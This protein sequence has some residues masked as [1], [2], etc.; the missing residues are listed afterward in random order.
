MEK[1]KDKF[2]NFSLWKNYLY[3]ENADKTIVLNKHF[4]FIQI[5]KTSSTN[6]LKESTK[7]RL[8]TKMNCYRH[9]GLA[10]K[11]SIV[12]NF[13]NYV[14]KNLDNIHTKQCIFLKSNRNIKVKTFKIE[15][16]DFNDYLIK[17][18]NI[19]L[20]LNENNHNKNQHE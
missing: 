4:L 17:H 20:K 3:K 18:H 6:V 12:Q 1:Q 15:N 7:R 2:E 19:D 11:L 9:E 10:Y 5:P 8:V 14:K 16:N 13:E